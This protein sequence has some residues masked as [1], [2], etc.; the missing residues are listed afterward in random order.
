MEM[1]DFLTYSILG[2]HQI[3]KVVPFFSFV[4]IS[5]D[6]SQRNINDQKIVW[7]GSTFCQCFFFILMRYNITL[8]NFIILQYSVG[9]GGGAT[10]VQRATK[11]FAKSQTKYGP[12]QEQKLVK[13]RRSN[14]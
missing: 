5:V 8:S 14:L 6:A 11:H 4:S 12:F 1:W 10:V 9:E 2:D 7:D 13:L 3:T